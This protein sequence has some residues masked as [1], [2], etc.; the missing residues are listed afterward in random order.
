MLQQT[1]VQAVIPFFER[2]MARFP[3]LSDLANADLDDVL[4]SWS[5]LGYYAR[6]R[7]MKLC[8]ELLMKQS[9]GVLPTT[10]EELE[11]LPGIGRYTA[12]AIASIA[13]GVVTPVVDVNVTR[14]LC[15]WYGLAVDTRAGDAQRKIWQLALSDIS[16]ARPGDYN[17]A[18]MEL[19]ALICSPDR[20]LCEQCPVSR[21][22]AAYA[23][24]QP[25]SYPL[26]REPKKWVQQVDVS[27][28]IV[29]ENKLL[30]VQRPLSGL[31]GGM[32]EMPRATAQ[33]GESIE[34]AAARAIRELVGVDIR[35]SAIIGPHKHV[36]M[37]R[38]ISLYAVTTL[39][40][41]R[42]INLSSRH[43]RWIE[44]DFAHRAAISA[45]QRRLIS[46]VFA[47]TRQLAL[48]E[49]PT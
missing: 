22:C 28:V 14:V 6:A 20:P 2:W 32:W 35:P 29:Q 11:K 8:A 34:D 13:F 27:A 46:L 25:S 15:R 45:P 16:S 19:G 21:F 3:T 10:P 26:P 4:A 5:G 38:K 37:N 41:E 44:V 36:V 9:S 12:G 18:L 31:W 42:F 33:D 43:V 7:N 48:S 49:I 1:T 40:T 23:S 47:N 30:I 24:G 39:D 17:Q